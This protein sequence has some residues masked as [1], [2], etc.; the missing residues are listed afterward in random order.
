MSKITFRADDDLVERIEA[1]DAS[2]SEVMREALRAYLDAGGDA[3]TD[4]READTPR[5]TDATADDAPDVS[6]DDRL[7]LLAARVDR[8]ADRIDRLA[9]AQ[10]PVTQPPAG[11]SSA[12]HGT[13]E[14]VS[15]DS[16]VTLS[17]DGVR[18]TP[19][20]ADRQP[21][22]RVP[23][24]SRLPATERGVP[25][26]E[27]RVPATDRRTPPTDRR[28]RPAGPPERP[29]DRRQTPP[30]GDREAAPGDAE[31]PTREHASRDE[32]ANASDTHGDTPEG[33]ADRPSDDAAR[34]TNT[35][36]SSD[37]RSDVR[38][39]SDT[40]A[41]GR[42]CAQCGTT[43]E[44]D[45]VYCPNCGEKTANRLFCEC[46]DEVR[47]DWSFCPGCGRRTP[48]ADVLSSDTPE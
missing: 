6:D 38:D 47:S 7:S 29:A 21:T 33:R 3:A 20:A 18:L 12:S 48:A 46:G 30:V 4:T 10:S 32:T 27:R 36:Q 41:G 35:R 14:R 9:A 43:V 39:A 34:E 5:S 8:L 17:I 26:T 42:A 1:H 23:A 16:T 13:N 37:T 15:D 22:R 24:D 19:T 25:A 31:R 2:K 45:H 11:D 40:D 44:S 28:E